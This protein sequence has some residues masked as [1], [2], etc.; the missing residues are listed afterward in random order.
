MDINLYKKN[1]EKAIIH[2]EN[3]FS[4]LQVWR[5]STWLVENIDIYIPDWDMKQKLNQLANITIID[6]QTIKI[7]PRDKSTLSKIEK[8]VYDSW[9]WL[10]PINNWDCILI[11]IPPL[12]KERR[13]ELTKIVSKQWE[14]AKISI[15]NIRHDWIKETKIQLDQKLIS[16]DQK[17]WF[18][19]QLDDIVKEFNNK[20]ESKVKFKSE[21]ILKL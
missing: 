21:E 14:E 18:E 10:T 13:M 7:E 15:R 20:I 2:L 19:K 4:H 9:L 16:E 17:K 8:W 11:K 3:E 5:A 1:M 12:T 6:T